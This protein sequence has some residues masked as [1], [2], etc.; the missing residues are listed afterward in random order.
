MPSS[1]FM[2]VLQCSALAIGSH[3][4]GDGFMFSDFRAQGTVRTPSPPFLQQLGPI[5]AVLNEN[6]IPV[7]SSPHRQE[8]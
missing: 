7:M 3:L 5:R 1:L 8:K 4:A 6:K 2:T